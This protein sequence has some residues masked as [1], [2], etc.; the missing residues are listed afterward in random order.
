MAPPPRRAFFALVALVAATVS[1]AFVPRLPATPPRVHHRPLGSTISASEVE[2]K[3]EGVWDKDVPPSIEAVIAQAQASLGAALEAGEKRIRVDIRTP[4]LDEALEQ[5]AIREKSLL[6]SVVGAFFPLLATAQKAKVLFESEVRTARSLSLSDLIRLSLPYELTRI[7]HTNDQRQGEAAMA[8]KA[9]VGNGAWDIPESV[10]FAGL[11]SR[12]VAPDDE[13]I[14]MV[15]PVNRA[16][17]PV[18]LTV[19]F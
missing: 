17:N 3:L 14:F 12:A 16:G 2:S 10:T 7:H 8:A 13:V 1:N 18:I 5:T 6:L 4:G 15:E 19:R 11:T 9:Y